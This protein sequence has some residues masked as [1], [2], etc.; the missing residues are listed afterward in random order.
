MSTRRTGV[1]EWAPSVAAD[2]LAPCP[3]CGHGANIILEKVRP[4]KIVNEKG[5]IG[6]YSGWA[7]RHYLLIACENWNCGI[8]TKSGLYCMIT[9]RDKG[10][11]LRAFAAARDVWNTRLNQNEVKLK[12]MEMSK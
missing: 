4:L 11:F 6:S 5:E 3:L 12:D 10:D 1:P 9:N 2:W 7:N 8:R